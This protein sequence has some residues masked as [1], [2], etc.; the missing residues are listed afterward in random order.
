MAAARVAIQRTYGT[1]WYGVD[2]D[3]LNMSMGVDDIGGSTIQMKNR[4]EQDKKEESRLIGHLV[5]P[6]DADYYYI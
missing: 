6:R 5:T 2:I 1:L 4:D 3:I